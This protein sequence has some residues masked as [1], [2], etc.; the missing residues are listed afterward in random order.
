[1]SFTGRECEVSPY[2]NSYESIN[3]VPIVTG[4]I[5]YTSPISGKRLILI[6]NEELWLGYQMQHTLLNPIQLL[7]FD[8]L[9]KDDP[10]ASDKPINIESENRDAVLP[11]H[12]EGTNIYLDI[13]TPTDK[14]LSQLP[15]LTMTSPHP[16]NP[17]KFQFPKTSRRVGEELTMRSITSATNEH[18]FST[19][20]IYVTTLFRSRPS[21][22]EQTTPL[23]LDRKSVV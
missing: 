5:G 15:H 12:V 17:I 2:S 9:V 4:A 18:G 11:L 10:F 7:S 8:M 3:K 19:I 21:G 13:W 6:F 22:V 23:G 1:M 14:D 20:K 16:W